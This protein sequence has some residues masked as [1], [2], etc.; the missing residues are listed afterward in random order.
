[1]RRNDRRN[2]S[3]KHNS[4]AG[5][6]TYAYPLPYEDIGHRG[7]T[8]CLVLPCAP[9]HR[10]R[11]PQ[12]PGGR[13]RNSRRSVSKHLL[14]GVVVVVRSHHNEPH[15]PWLALNS[16]DQTYTFYCNNKSPHS[17][18]GVLNP[19][20]EED[21]SHRPC[22]AVHRRS[23]YCWSSVLATHVWWR[24]WWWWLLLSWH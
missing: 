15:I 16:Q 2:S 17:R 13:R 18:T 23:G 8:E 1:M 21:T 3:P 9:P 11:Y 24:R 6:S 12:I 10:Q 4:P 7:R 14:V 20:K 19:S 5:H 22:T